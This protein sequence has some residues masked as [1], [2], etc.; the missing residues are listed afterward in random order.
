MNI[1]EYTTTQV[2]ASGSVSSTTLHV[3]GGLIRQ[4]YIAG[5]DSNTLFRADLQNNNNVTIMNYGYHRGMINDVD[6]AVPVHGELTV[7][8]TNA[9]PQDN[10]RV[11]I[12]V[13][14]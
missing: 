5:T 1:Y 13:E 4:F 10:F 12:G 14:E 7:N 6:H 11:I 9:T 8:I 3:N 2:T